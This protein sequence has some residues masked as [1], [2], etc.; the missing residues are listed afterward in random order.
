MKG[1]PR[2]DQFDDIYFSAEDGLAETQHVFIQGNDLPRAWA[3][4]NSFVICE[5]G[6]GTGLNFLTAW[7]LFD[8]TAKNAQG[9][10]FISF[11]KYPLTSK[12]IKSALAPWAQYFGRRID[13][14]CD[15]YPL[16]IA[17]F[18]RI[19]MS[20]NIT[21]TLIFDD[22]NDAIQQI[23]TTVDC[24][25]LDGFT[26]AKN[27]DMWSDTLFQNMA[28]LSRKGTSFATF[29]AA[30]DVRRGL[31]ESGFSVE[32]K[33][34][35]GRK[36]DMIAGKFEGTDA[37][38]Q[39]MIGN[40]IAIIG[41]GLAGTSCAYVLKQYGFNPIIYEREAALATGASGNA[42]GL[43]NPRFT[44][45]RD[46]VSNFFVPAYAQII[47]LA[48]KAADKIDYNPCGALHLIN[49]PE[50]EK[51]F[52]NLIENWGWHSDHVQILSAKEASAVSGVAIDQRCLYLPD[53]GAL[54]P[55][56][57]CHYMADDIDVRTLHHISDLSDLKAHAIILCNAY[58]TKEFIEWLPLET[59]RGQISE[60]ETPSSLE[61][62][63]CNI[64]Y[65]GYVSASKKGSNIL[66]ATFQKWLDHKD[67]TDEDHT[68]N[69]SKLT[70]ALP[71][72][73]GSD[74][75]IKSGRASLRT[76]MQDRFPVVGIVPGYENV[77]V[78]AAFGSHGVV[79]ALQSAHYLADLLRNGP[80]CLPEMTAKALAPQRFLDRM[81]KKQA[82]AN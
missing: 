10:D 63:N 52:E 64:H 80:L 34:G 6:F 33:K 56:K 32:K 50:K 68:D 23:S 9:L 29:T 4:K 12:A 24:W 38:L 19:K 48:E 49:T 76:A 5:T 37:P 27:P 26:P 39:K 53:S 59:V 16:R 20:S 69:I 66:G 18:H 15:N 30:G 22:V 7:K 44:A 75:K 17:G 67:V 21:L 51:R 45:Q 47:R 11:E 60:V 41:G 40:N 74:F 28:Q 57:L 65:G 35:F 13:T 25:F 81:A 61:S 73:K 78:S 36:R 77:F 8:E 54:S 2:S 58:A 71:F 70:Q 79:G 1:A 42:I 72:L 43:Y 46:A 3:G 31:T 62:L 55:H 82:K 14:L